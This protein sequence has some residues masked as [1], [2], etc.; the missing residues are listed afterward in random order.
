MSFLFFFP[1]NRFWHF[2]HIVSNG[3]N[4]HEMSNPYFWEKQKN[5]ICCGY[6]MATICMKCQI[7]FSWKNKKNI[8]NLSSAELAKGVVMINYMA[9]SVYHD[10]LKIQF[11]PVLFISLVYVLKPIKMY[12]WTIKSGP[13]LSASRKHAYIILTPL[14]LILYS[15]TGVY[16]GI[17]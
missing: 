1:E 14:N 17:H 6:S 10:W 8:T 15:K 11:C 2:T 3:D 16:R 7:L 4:L 9:T 12:I 13:L 5:I